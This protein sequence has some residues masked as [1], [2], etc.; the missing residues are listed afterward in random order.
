MKKMLI[1]ILSIFTLIAV[2]S[3]QTIEGKWQIAAEDGALGVGPSLEDPTGY[4]SWD[5]AA[6]PRAC[7]TDDYYIFNSD[8]SFHNVVGDQTWYEADHGIDGI[9][10]EGCYNAVAPWD[11]QTDASYTV[12]EAAGTVTIVGEGAFLGLSKVTNTNNNGLP[13]DN[14]TTY[15]YKITGGGSRME[16]TILNNDGTL[17]WI[18]KFVRVG[19]SGL[20]GSWSFAKQAGAFGVGP[21]AGDN[22]WWANSADDLDLRACIFDDEYIFNADGSFKNVLGETTWLEASFQGVAADGCGA[23]VA[24]HDGSNAATWSVDE[25]AG[26]ITLVGE[27]SFLGLAKANNQNETGTPTDN[28]TVLSYALSDGGKKLSVTVNVGG[29][30]FWNYV[31]TKNGSP[32]FPSALADTKWKLAPLAGALG[33]GDSGANWW[34]SSAEDVET[35]SCLFDDEYAFKSDGSFENV[36]GETTWLETWQ[37]VAEGCGTPI[38][39]HDGSNAATWKE[40]D[41]AKTI[42]IVGEGA[43]LGLAKVH[44]TAEDGNPVDNTI[45][46]TYSMDGIYLNLEIAGFNSDVPGAKWY[47]KMIPADADVTPPAAPT[48]VAALPGVYQNAITW[49]DV[50]DASEVGETYTVL[51]SLEPFSSTDPKVLMADLDVDVVAEGILEDVGEAYHHIY[52]PLEDRVRSYYYAVIAKDAYGNA[53]LAGIMEAS[54]SNVAKGVPTIALSGTPTVVIDGEL[55]EWTSS[56]IVPI[57]LGPE[58]NSSGNP[59][60]IGTVDDD[61]DASVTMSIAFDQDSMYIAAEVWDDYVTSTSGVTE[62]WFQDALELFIGLYDQR[63]ARGSFNAKGSGQPD[64][65]FVF[66]RDSVFVDGFGKQ[67]DLTDK[68]WINYVNT[69][70]EGSPD[71]NIEVAISLDSLLTL[72]SYEANSKFVAQEGMRIIFE[73]VLHDND[74][75]WEGNVV[76]NSMNNDNAWQTKAVWSTTFIGRY[77]GDFLNTDEVKTTLTEFALDKNYPNPFNPTTTISY[78]IGMAGQTRLMIYDLL[79]REVARLVDDYKPV[80]VYRVTWNA[81]KVP[82]GV[83]L[84]RL[85]SSS[86]TKTEK[87]VLIK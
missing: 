42:T 63:G 78:S 43:Y 16:V 32:V 8:G 69:G 68:S 64:Y 44:N 49:T 18:F 57:E 67:T 59:K 52:S 12:D 22:S 14:T 2:S 76:Y 17:G 29:T 87:M 3:A 35:R 7:L 23:P 77:D 65:K 19:A 80:G 39:P 4:W 61:L 40:D 51:A 36:L 86:F 53:S 37:N 6:Q 31:F 83:Y 13:V 79:G 82:S 27:G 46:Y 47:F 58:T 60:V 73:P 71:Y 34:A 85:E 62:W 15:N 11:G 10:A 20:E 66:M 70:V 45:V 28:T 75:A 74:G 41:V 55:D 54:Q 33:V 84:Y 30:V 24:P 26:T 50:E 48:S 1:T 25:N 5:V 56:D 21:A 81:S 38:A 72:E 9:T